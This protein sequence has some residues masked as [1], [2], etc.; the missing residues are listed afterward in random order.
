MKNGLL[1]YLGFHSP[2]LTRP[3]ALCL[4]LVIEFSDFRVTVSSLLFCAEAYNWN[5]CFR[6]MSYMRPPG[7]GTRPALGCVPFGGADDLA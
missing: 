6:D 4:R 1:S 2:F 5:R 3:F 7:N